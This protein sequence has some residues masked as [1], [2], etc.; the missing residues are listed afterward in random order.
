MASGLHSERVNKEAGT[1]ASRERRGE[2]VQENQGLPTFHQEG[3]PSQELAFAVI[4][5]DLAL[6]LVP[7]R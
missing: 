4:P 1:R 6:A 2:S 7:A 5:R 3:C